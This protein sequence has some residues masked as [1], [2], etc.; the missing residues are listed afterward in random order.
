MLGLNARISY[1]LNIII[2]FSLILLSSCDLT[3][4]TIDSLNDDAIDHPSNEENPFYDLVDMQ[5]E[6]SE[7]SKF[8]IETITNNTDH[9]LSFS[10]PWIEYFNGTNWQI[11]PRNP[12]YGIEDE[13]YGVGGNN[14][15]IFNI[16]LIA[17][18]HPDYPNVGN[19]RIGRDVYKQDRRS[20]VDTRVWF[21]L[22]SE[23]F[24]LE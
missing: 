1:F 3:G 14:S 17:F 18:I 10:H 4:A 12:E 15:S 11:I 13:F 9:G 19:F 8:I 22:H 24:I 7:D 23:Y 20:G 21:T 2:F 5:V 6:L 16:S